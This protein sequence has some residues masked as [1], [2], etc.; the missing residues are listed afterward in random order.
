MTEADSYEDDICVFGY[1]VGF[2]REWGYFCLSE[3]KSVDINGLKVLRDVL[4]NLICTQEDCPERLKDG[5]WDVVNDNCD[6]GMDFSEHWFS[7]RIRLGNRYERL[8]EETIA[9][10]S[11]AVQ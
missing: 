6:D 7:R 4:L 10:N 9:E 8:E 3:L 1:V 11:E 5:I 2:E